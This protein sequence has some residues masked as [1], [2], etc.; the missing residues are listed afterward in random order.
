MSRTVKCDY[1]MQKR[2]AADLPSKTQRLNNRKHLGF[3]EP[4]ADQGVQMLCSEILLPLLCA[5]HSTLVRSG[6][7]N[8]EGPPYG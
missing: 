7:E 3:I 1:P 4:A 2:R 5:E 8:T 6:R